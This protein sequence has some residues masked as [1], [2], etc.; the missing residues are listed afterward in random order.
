MSFVPLYQPDDDIDAKVAPED[1]TRPNTPSPDHSYSSHLSEN[2]VWNRLSDWD[3]LIIEMDSEPTCVPPLY[4]GP[5]DSKN[6]VGFYNIYV[7]DLP[8]CY[9][10]W[11]NVASRVLGYPNNHFKKYKTYAE[12]MDGWKEYCLAHHKHGPDFVSSM[13]YEHP[14]SSPSPSS[15][16]P[17]PSNHNVVSLPSPGKEPLPRISSPAVPSPITSTPVLQKGF[18]KTPV[19]PKEKKRANL[20]SPSK[21]ASSSSP[22]KHASSS[23]TISSAS[24]FSVS[25]A[26]TRIPIPP[27]TPVR[28]RLWAVHTS[29]LNCVVSA[30]EADRILNEG[31]EL[32]EEVFVLE[33]KSIV[34]ADNWLD[35]IWV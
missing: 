11:A 31:K 24:S 2:S 30:E 12:A 16:I 33:V 35:S 34:E 5:G 8:G 7:G 26:G 25:S 17:P 3:P 27:R 21:I 13:Q 6:L 19:K 20:P 18:P 1:V 10:D 4:D 32:G 22:S 29:N 23:S 15:S 14:S 28:R 9:R